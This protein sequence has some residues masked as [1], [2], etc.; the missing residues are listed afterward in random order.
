MQVKGM[1]CL[2]CFQAPGPGLAFWEPCGYMGLTSGLMLFYCYLKNLNTFCTGPCG[3]CSWLCTGLLLETGA[4]SP[5]ATASKL[6]LCFSNSSLP[7]DSRRQQHELHI[8]KGTS[9]REGTYPREEGNPE[10]G[11]ICHSEAPAYPGSTV[12]GLEQAR[13]TPSDVIWHKFLSSLHTL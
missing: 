11:G 13:K 2:S 6:L 3:L 1:Y 5:M 12:Q 7:C 9:Q 8:H 4:L 10:R